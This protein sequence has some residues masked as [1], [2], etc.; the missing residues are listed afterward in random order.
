MQNLGKYLQKSEK[1]DT[2]IKIIQSI[3]PEGPRGFCT[4]HPNPK[5]RIQIRL[6]KSNE[7]MQSK[8]P[9]DLF[10]TILIISKILRTLLINEVTFSYFVNYQLSLFV[11]TLLSQR[12]LRFV[13]DYT[14]RPQAFTTSCHSWP[15][16]HVPR[17]PN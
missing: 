12:I 2:F 16:F 1:L 15:E 4:H 6:S 14:F 8:N 11:M 13:K 3:L 5:L 10:S 9:R 7:K 17:S